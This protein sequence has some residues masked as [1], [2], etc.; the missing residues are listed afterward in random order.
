MPER[1]VKVDRMWVG[2]ATLLYFALLT[3]CKQKHYFYK[4]P[5]STAVRCQAGVCGPI[6]VTNPFILSDLILLQVFETSAPGRFLPG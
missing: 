3:D 5:P 1:T 2:S 4:Q 6:F